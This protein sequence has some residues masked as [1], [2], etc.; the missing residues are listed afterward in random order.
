VLRV[1][2]SG[3]RVRQ[4]EPLPRFRLRSRGLSPIARCVKGKRSVI[5]IS[6]FPQDVM[7][8]ADRHPVLRDGR[9][10]A[11]SDKLRQTTASLN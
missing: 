11:T 7:R 8:V 4:D 10:S 1:I 6:H 2:V 3:A 5:Y 9:K